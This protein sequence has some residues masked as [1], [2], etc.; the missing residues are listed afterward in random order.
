[1]DNAE[2]EMD[3]KFKSE[4]HFK[5]YF[6]FFEPFLVP[7]ALKFPENAERAK[8]KIQMNSAATSKNAEFHA[9]SVEKVS[10]K[11]TQKRY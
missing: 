11:F 1:M 4:T 8:N 2:A 9:K 6:S 7:L 3:A 10:N 5:R